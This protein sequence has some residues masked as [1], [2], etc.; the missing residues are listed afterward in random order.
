ML[1]GVLPNENG[2]TDVNVEGYSKLL[3]AD[4]A[5]NARAS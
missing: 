2:G 1:F 4:L 3:E 5:N